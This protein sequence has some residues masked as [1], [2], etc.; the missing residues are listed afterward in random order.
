MEGNLVN[1]FYNQAILHPKQLA[2]VSKKRSITYFE[3]FNQVQQTAASYHKKGLRKGDKV[4]VFVP[5]SIELYR[6]ILA[7]FHLGAI[8]VFLDE[9]S[10]VRRLNEAA[11]TAKCKALIATWKGQILAW[12]IKGL[13]SIKLKIMTSESNNNY[14]NVDI[15]AVSKDDP[16]LITFSTGSTGKPKAAIRTYSMLQNQFE[17]LKIYIDL[18]IQNSD[19]TSLPIVLMINLGLGKTTIIPDTNL[20]KLK[21]WI[22]KEFI[23]K[24]FIT[25]FIHC[26][27]HLFLPSGMLTIY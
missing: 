27:V 25:R 8:P 2:I 18:N 5:M 4:L 16:V 7:L 13:R 23:I 21:I 11:E 12:F 6:I 26:L 17:A 19:M 15:A 3:L 1:Q 22:Q 14:V 20:K 10:S 9:W 24:W